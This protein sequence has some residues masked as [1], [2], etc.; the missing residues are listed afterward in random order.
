M[1]ESYIY[2]DGTRYVD[3][4]PAV[5]RMRVGTSAGVLHRDEST[6]SERPSCSFCGAKARYSRACAGGDWCC[7]GCDEELDGMRAAV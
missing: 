7:R 2:S 1:R 4:G 3:H 6:V 5:R